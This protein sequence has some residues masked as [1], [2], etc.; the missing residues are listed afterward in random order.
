MKKE[1]TNNLYDWIGI[2]IVP[3]I[4]IVIIFT[5]F[6]RSSRRGRNINDEY[7]A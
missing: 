7:S 1:S 2:I 4:A 6:F 3:L 5:F